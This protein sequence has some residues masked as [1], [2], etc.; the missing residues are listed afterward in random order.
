MDQSAI[1]NP[2]SFGVATRLIDENRKS[3]DWWLDYLALNQVFTENEFYILF[4]DGLL[5]KKGRAKFKTS[6]YLKG[7]KLFTF[8]QFYDKE[9]IFKNDANNYRHSTSSDLP[10]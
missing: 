6:Q 10:C 2:F 1:I 8:K 4:A 3:P 9:K 7:D 5:V